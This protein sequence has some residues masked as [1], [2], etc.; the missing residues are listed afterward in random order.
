MMNQR[1][2]RLLWI[3]IVHQS[4][5]I[6]SSGVV[7]QDEVIRLPAVLPAEP[8]P[9]GQLVSHPDSSSVILQSPGDS[10][11]APATPEPDHPR[12]PPGVRNGIFQK[13]LFDGTWLAPGGANGM[14]M[15]DLQLQ[16][17]FAL[18]CPSAS[19]RW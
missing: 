13:A 6:A 8:S 16:G 10:D 5:L 1:L 9:P 18:P 14:G 17:I 12:L 2:R 11:V 19:R 7:A 4:S 3:V 15:S